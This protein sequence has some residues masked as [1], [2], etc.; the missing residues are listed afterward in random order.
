MYCYH[1]NWYS[2]GILC[3]C[4]VLQELECDLSTNIII[5][6]LL[7]QLPE[8]GSPL[9]NVNRQFDGSRNVI[10]V[11]LKWTIVDSFSL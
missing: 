11:D 2:A 7:V 6:H 10:A 5:K 9:K 4:L 1:G 8:A 3:C